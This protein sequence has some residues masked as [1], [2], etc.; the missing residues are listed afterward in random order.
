MGI[1]ISFNPLVTRTDHAKQSTDSPNTGIQS[2]QPSN[3]VS[4]IEITTVDFSWSSWYVEYDND[5]DGKYDTID[6]FYGFSDFTVSEWVYFEIEIRIYY[7][8]QEWKYIDDDGEWFEEYVEPSKT[9]IWSYQWK[10]WYDGNYS[11]SIK[12]YDDSSDELAI[13]ETITWNDASEFI[14]LNDWERWIEEFDEDDDSL[15]DTIEIWYSFNFTFSDWVD[16]DFKIEIYYWD[17]YWDYIDTEWE[18]FGEDVTAEEV[19]NVSFQWRS[20]YDGDY[21]FS[22]RIRNYNTDKP[23]IEDWVAWNE[24]SSFS[25][26]YNYN[27]WVDKYDEDGDGCEDTISIE[28]SFNFTLSDPVYLEI[29]MDIYY[30]NGYWE[31]IATEW[32]YFGEDVTAGEVY[33]VSFQWIAWYDGDYNLS[34]KIRDE[35][36][37][38]NLIEEWITW[39]GACVFTLL[40]S[41]D[42]WTMELDEDN[43][44]CNDTIELEYKFKFSYTGQVNMRIRVEISY[45]NPENGDWD[46]IDDHYDYIEESVTS[47][48]QLTWSFRWQAW[49]GGKYEFYVDIEERNYDIL[50]I[51]ES[52][53]WYADCAFNPIKEWD[54]WYKEYDKDTDDCD[55]TIEIGF[56]MLFS[57]TGSIALKLRAQVHYWNTENNEWDYINS[58]NEEF[59]GDIKTDIWYYCSFKWSAGQVGDYK[60]EIVISGEN[61]GIF[62]EDIIQ[63][64]NACAFEVLNSWDSWYKEYDEDNDGYNDTINIGYD[65]RFTFSGW[66]DLYLSAEIRH[67]NEENAD[68]EEVSYTSQRFH[69]QVTV[70]DLNTFSFLWP[71]TKDGDFQFQIYIRDYSTERL[72]ID[73]TIEWQDACQYKLIKNWNMWYNE[74]DEDTDGLIDTIEVNFDMTF[75]NSGPVFL[76]ALMRVHYWNEET[77]NWQE[78]YTYF[79]EF[80]S[81]EVKEGSWYTLNITW[82][83]LYTGDYN[84]SVQLADLS[85]YTTNM[86]VEEWIEWTDVTAYQGVEFEW[87]RI[88]EDYYEDRPD[89]IDI[90]YEFLFSHSGSVDFDIRI[91][92]LYLDYTTLKFDLKTIFWDSFE[93]DVTEGKWYGWV[94]NW[95]LSDTEGYQVY[96]FITIFDGRARIVDDMVGL[97]YYD[98]EEPQQILPIETT[99]STTTTVTTEEETY[100][101]TSSTPNVTSGWTVAAILTMVI[102]ILS[103]TRGK[104]RIG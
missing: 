31:D 44:G 76:I 3:E 72:L 40:D 25:Y 87:E 36:S 80:F 27:R 17:E 63:W 12:I 92:V 62:I 37:D 9:Y 26:F 100:S 93:T 14:F 61:S 10:A 78:I 11:F 7:W 32:E 102:V 42:S 5:S 8:D 81:E 51:E 101:T 99:S 59:V 94:K 75:S 39:S 53:E 74:Y 16:M 35:Y 33:N 43:D 29:R 84:V 66:A 55:D 67:W 34:I 13:E 85:A 88:H 82:S 28:Y 2:Q 6:I 68:W 45:W 18:Y 97:Y 15:N 73:E 95:D 1:L 23:I 83:A 104:R 56:D 96:F 64:D 65:L 38:R 86:Q 90:G 60:I 69:K 71:A 47:G 49:D 22:I 58:Y 19:Y 21:N 48:Y 46:W 89:S 103:I 52:F 98:H 41:W 77:Q 4:H 20:W 79:Y 54:S 50:L 24:A 57:I 91:H 70:G 30:W